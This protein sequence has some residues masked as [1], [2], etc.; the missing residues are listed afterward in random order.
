MQLCGRSVSLPVRTQLLNYQLIEDLKMSSFPKNFSK[1]EFLVSV[2]AERHGIDN[3]P[4]ETISENLLA[5]ANVLQ[6][7][8]DTL[9]FRTGIERPIFVSSGYR[10]HRLNWVITDDRYSKS[11]HSSGLAAD[12]SIVGMTP[13]EVTEFIKVHM[14]NLKFHKIINEYDKWIHLSIPLEHENAQCIML[15]AERGSDG[16]ARYTNV[17]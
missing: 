15:K 9:F 7:I 3:T 13:R 5:L 12:I 10:C 14:P 6:G 2:T 17:F 1:N 4:D 11:R 8:R 16:K